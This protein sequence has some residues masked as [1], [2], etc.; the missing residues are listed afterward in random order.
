M[1]RREEM[2]FW[3]KL[4]ILEVLKGFSLTFGTLL[5]NFILHVLNFLGIKTDSSA[6]VVVQY[7]NERR[8]YPERYRGRHRLTLKPNGDI[9]CTAC[10]LCATACPAR[11]IYIEACEHDDPN[12]EKFPHRYEIDTLLCIYCGYCVEACPVDAIR[13]DTGIHPEVYQPD[14]RLFIEDK[15]VLMQR[16]KDLHGLSKQ[17]IFKHHQQKIQ[18]LEKD[19]I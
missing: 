1:R 13:M 19:L 4:Y 5:K 7:P 15:E 17:E 10:F 9:R 3:E 11:C 6:S 16:S 14:P 2:S 18:N 8:A 12:I